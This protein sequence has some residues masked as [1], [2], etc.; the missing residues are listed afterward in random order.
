MEQKII[1]SQSSSPIKTQ[2][3]KTRLLAD[4]QLKTIARSDILD[5]IV[6]LRSEIKSLKKSIN[7]LARVKTLRFNRYRRGS[8]SFELSSAQSK[9]DQQ[10]LKLLEKENRLSLEEL[11]LQ[12]E[13]DSLLASIREA[14]SY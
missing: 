3:C 9:L 4:R 7:I 5:N 8:I 10:K 14:A 1:E 12:D 13:N 11:R 6:N 2:I